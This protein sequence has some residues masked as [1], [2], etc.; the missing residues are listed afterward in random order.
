MTWRRIIVAFLAVVVLAEVFVPDRY[1]R[2][3]E[4][5]L[6]VLDGMAQKIDGIAAMGRRP[7]PNDLTELIYPLTRARQFTSKYE[8][9]GGRE[10]YRE[11]LEVVGAYEQLVAAVDAA[12]G[13]DASWQATRQIVR[14]QVRVVAAR[15]VATRAALAERS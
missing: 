5:H 11:F 12:R 10:S 3:I 4:V 13:T 8:S 6:D 1:E 14:D 15:V 7:S 9:E 2:V